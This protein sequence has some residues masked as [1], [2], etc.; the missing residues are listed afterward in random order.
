M[1]RAW[2]GFPPRPLASCP[3]R[4]LDAADPDGGTGEGPTLTS[5]DLGAVLGAVTALLS[6]VLGVVTGLLQ[7]VLG[8]VGGLLGGTPLTPPALLPAS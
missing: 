2:S 4:R 7:P 8:V 3:V 5:L 1:R 6:P